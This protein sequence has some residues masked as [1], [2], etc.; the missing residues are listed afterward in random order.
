MSN[1]HD[2]VGREK[3]FISGVILAQKMLAANEIAAISKRVVR[4]FRREKRCNTIRSSGKN[5]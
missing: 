2:L 5:R 3:K 1:S 4:V